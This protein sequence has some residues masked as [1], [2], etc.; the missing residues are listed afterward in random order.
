MFPLKVIMGK[1]GR[2]TYINKIVSNDYDA[3]IMS[4]EMFESI[5][6]S[7]AAQKGVL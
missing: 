3:V 5:P 2:K 6:L 1:N 7:P 4:Y